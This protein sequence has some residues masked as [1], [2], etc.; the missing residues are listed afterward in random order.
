[1]VRKAAKLCISFD[2]NNDEEQITYVSCMVDLD[3]IFKTIDE[4]IYSQIS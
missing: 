2:E 4:R 3:V 1:M